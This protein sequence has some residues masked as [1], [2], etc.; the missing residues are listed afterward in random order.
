[1]VEVPGISVKPPT[2]AVG[3][4]V[5]FL[6][7]ELVVPLGTQELLIVGNDPGQLPFILSRDGL[8]KSRQDQLADAF[9][10]LPSQ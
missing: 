1:L 9:P 8:M 3:H 4:V 6:L 7:S 5:D 2:V 10:N